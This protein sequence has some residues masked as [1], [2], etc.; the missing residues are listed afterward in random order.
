MA[1]DLLA[2]QRALLFDIG[3]RNGTTWF[4]VRDWKFGN[5]DIAVSVWLS[6]IFRQ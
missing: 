5:D 1:L 3:S 4:A 6:Q 2:N